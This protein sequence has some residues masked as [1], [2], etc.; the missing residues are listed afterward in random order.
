[1]WLP[2]RPSTWP[3]FGYPVGFVPPPHFTFRLSA[4][5]HHRLTA[6]RGSHIS[7]PS[8]IVIQLSSFGSTY[9]PLTMAT[10]G[11]ESRFERMSVNDENDPSDSSKPYSKT[12]VSTSVD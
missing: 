12:K 9:Q 3:N 10:R 7:S 1:M 2:W 11:L 8:L 6:H 4:P 5:E